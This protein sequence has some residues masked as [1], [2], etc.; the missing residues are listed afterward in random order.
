ML[1]LIINHF[2]SNYNIQD[3]K[4]GKNS[5]HIF[6]FFIS[7]FPQ[8]GS[9]FIILKTVR[10]SKLFSDGKFSDFFL[11]QQL[12]NTTI[13]LFFRSTFLDKDLKAQSTLLTSLWWQRSGIMAIPV[14]EFSRE[15]YKIIKFL[16]LKINHSQM[17]SISE[18][19][20]LLQFSIL[21]IQ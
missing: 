10:Y 8:K 14:V 21:K 17:K 12:G 4:W 18:S 19:L 1:L 20:P 3:W 16:L 13:Q 11:L 9:T 6:I 7:Q 15:G 5:D 2:S